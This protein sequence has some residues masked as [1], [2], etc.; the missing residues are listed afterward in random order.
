[1][2][3]NGIFSWF[4]KG[5]T[6]S[7][8]I[9][10]VMKV[11]TFLMLFVIIHVSATSYSQNSHLSLNMKNVS[12][13]DVLIRIEEQTEYRFLY[14]DSKIDVENKVNIDLNDMKIEDILDNVFEGTNIG[15]R[16]VNRQILLSGKSD[17]F[18]VGLQSNN[19]KGKVTGFIWKSA[20]WS[21]C[22]GERNDKWHDYRF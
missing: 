12:I 11:F 4:G 22:S 13:K 2:K 7:G 1:M 16:I 10:K 15:Y 18:Q 14:S 19:I 17:A 8:K 3:K 21:Y 6:P 20:S 5:L 9:L